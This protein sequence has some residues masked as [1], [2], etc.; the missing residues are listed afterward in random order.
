MITVRYTIKHLGVIHDVGFI[1]TNHVPNLHEEIESN[2][3]E[4]FLPNVRTFVVQNITNI[5]DDILFN[6]DYKEITLIPS[7]E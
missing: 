7:N 4:K 2:F 3:F 1:E 6:L 5:Y